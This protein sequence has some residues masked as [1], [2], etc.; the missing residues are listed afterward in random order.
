MN[1]YDMAR[2]TYAATTAP[3]RTDRDTEY[4]AFARI[5]R[6]M[7]RAASKPGDF[8]LLAKALHDN[9]RLWNILAA[10]IASEGNALPAHL[11]AQILY[12]AEF[13]AVQSRRVLNHDAAI[14]VLIDINTAIMRGLR[15]QETVA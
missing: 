4:D 1:A 12:L 13:T 11:R 5:T 6:Q 10:D 9:R 3:V 15:N 8:P 7:K 2:T 14:D